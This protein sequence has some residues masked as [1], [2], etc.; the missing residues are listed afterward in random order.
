[1]A[2]RTN[3]A[4]ENTGNTFDFEETLSHRIIT[5]ARRISRVVTSHYGD[6]FDLTPAELA[7]LGAVGRAG[8]L[9]PSAIADTIAFDKV[10]V[11]RASATLEARGLVRRSAD[12]KDGR[13]RV[14]RLTRRGQTIHA[15]VGPV[16]HDLE[17][18]L[19]RGLGRTDMTVFIRVLAKLNTTLDEFER[20]Q[21][22][23]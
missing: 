16:A 18:E 11:S 3:K 12:P 5:T 17:T 21:A 15:K 22:G 14:L 10:R 6:A 1:M 9:S 20:D 23:G 13:G 19:L 8:A 2:L 4:D 7:V